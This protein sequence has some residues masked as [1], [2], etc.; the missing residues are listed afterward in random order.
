MYKKMN[1]KLITFADIGIEKYE[2]HSPK[3]SITF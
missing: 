2:F 3:N 1:K